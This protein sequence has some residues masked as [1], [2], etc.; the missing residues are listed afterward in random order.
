MKHIKIFEDY[1]EEE[2]RDLQDTLHDIGHKTKFV[3]GEDFGFQHSFGIHSKQF[4]DPNNGEWFP[5]IS[6]EMF[7]ALLDKGEIVKTPS[8]E[9]E[10]KFKNDKDFGI[11]DGFESKISRSGE[12][13]FIQINSTT[14]SLLDHQE[15]IPI[16]DKILKKLGEVRI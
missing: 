2:L 15:W 10:F 1:S 7:K 14:G 9:P 6:S 5:E 8:F 12:V 3:Q 4:K 13:Y 11:D 16:F